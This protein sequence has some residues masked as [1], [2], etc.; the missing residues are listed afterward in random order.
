MF[1]KLFFSTLL[2]G[3]LSTPLMAETFEEAAKPWNYKTCPSANASKGRNW[4]H[5]M[6]GDRERNFFLLGE[7]VECFRSLV[8]NSRPALLASL[9]GGYPMAS[10]P[11][12]ATQYHPRFTSLEFDIHETKDHVL[13]L[14]HDSHLY[15]KRISRYTYAYWKSKFDILTVQEVLD[16]ATKAKLVKP[17]ALDIKNIYSDT[18][19]FTMLEMLKVYVANT[20]GRTWPD[21]TPVVWSWKGP[22]ILLTK[23]TDAFKSNFTRNSKITSIAAW[24]AELDV[25]GF[26]GVQNYDG[27]N[28]CAK[29]QNAPIDEEQPDKEENPTQYPDDDIPDEPCMS[30]IKC[31]IEAR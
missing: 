24:C 8:E 20:H 3:G 31:D 11:T 7:G 15:D 4:G 23:D 12:P 22:A 9:Y 14:S 5:R 19:R 2:I 29:Y 1:K 21:G 16:E 30:A 25:R 6:G 27:K 17:L 26:F 28:L 10:D 18:A 13:V